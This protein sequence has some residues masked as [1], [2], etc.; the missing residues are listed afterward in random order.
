MTPHYAQPIHNALVARGQGWPAAG[1]LFFLLIASAVLVSGFIY[2]IYYQAEAIKDGYKLQQLLFLRQELERQKQR[3][4]L[5]K[6]QAR[7]L[8]VIESLARGLGL[9]RPD[10]SQVISPNSRGEVKWWIRVPSRKAVGDWSQSGVGSSSASGRGTVADTQPDPQQRE[11][12]RT[13][14]TVRSR[15]KRVE[16]VASVPT[17]AEDADAS[18]DEAPQAWLEGVLL[19][20]EEQAELRLEKV[21][22]RNQR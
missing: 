19:Y 3:L 12:I 10:S 13:A 15:P 16:A 4:E 14:P 11:I 8:H 1:R 18:V 7:S 2:A 6:A 22:K 17:P 21:R 9:V 5:E 20:A